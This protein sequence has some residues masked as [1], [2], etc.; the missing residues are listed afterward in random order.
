MT[1]NSSRCLVA[2]AA[3]LALFAL[4]PII[5]ADARGVT[6]PTVPVGNVGNANDPLTGNLYGGVSYDYR[7]GTTEVT[8]AQYADFLNA[9]AASDPLGPLQHEHGQ[10]CSRRHH[11]QRR[12][13]QLHLRGQDRHGQQ[14]RELCELVRLDPL[15]QLAQQRAGDRRHGNRRVHAVCGG[16]PTPS[17]GLSITRNVGATVVPDQ[18]KRVVQG[19]LL[20]ARRA[21]GRCGQLLALSHGQQQRAHDRHGQAACGDISNPGANVA[22]YMS[23]ADWNGQDGNV[24]TVGSA[25]PLSESFYGTSDQGGNVCEW[26]EALIGGS[27]RG[28]RGGSFSGGSTFVLQSSFLYRQPGLVVRERRRRIPRGNRP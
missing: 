7:I 13:R 10:R 26:N 2:R 25:G 1:H 14:A 18:R 3:A 15:C 23:G 24:T 16:T 19:G 9:K 27:F 5:A 12:Q 20:S 11:A 8:N 17:N 4:V 21:G 28:L 22:N 6:I